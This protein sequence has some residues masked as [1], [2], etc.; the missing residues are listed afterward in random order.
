MIKQMLLLYR[1]L[2]R[3]LNDTDPESSAF[4]INAYKEMWDE[5]GMISGNHSELAL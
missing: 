2:C 4:Y 5:D 3:Y 1:K